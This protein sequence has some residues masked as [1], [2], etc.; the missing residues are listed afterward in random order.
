MMP[1][2]TDNICFETV[3]VVKPNIVCLR[4]YPHVGHRSMWVEEL[5]DD[6]GGGCNAEDD[7]TQDLLPPGEQ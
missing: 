6:V 5:A 2:H 1:A 7:G 4:S 3:V